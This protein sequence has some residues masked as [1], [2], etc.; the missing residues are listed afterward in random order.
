MWGKG[1]TVTEAVVGHTTLIAQGTELTGDICFN[2]NLEIEGTI[3]G[4]IIAGAGKEAFVRI[5]QNGRVEG[6]IKAPVVVIN[7]SVCGDVY[8]GEKVELAAQAVVDGDVHYK[9]I[10]MAMG[11]QVN[12]NMVHQQESAPSTAKATDNVV[13]VEQAKAK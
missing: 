2:G 4:N 10:E 11:A 5:L 12:G 7:G 6:E 1:K 3:R 13:S 9:L 8:A